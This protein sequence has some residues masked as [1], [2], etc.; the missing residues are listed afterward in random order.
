MKLTKEQIN[1]LLAEIR[2]VPGITFSDYTVNLSGDVEEVMINYDS[3]K[4][5]QT[6]NISF[7][8]SKNKNKVECSAIFLN[9]AE[10]NIL[11][12]FNYTIITN[13][14]YTTIVKFISDCENFIVKNYGDYSTKEGQL[15]IINN[16]LAG[17][18]FSM[19]NSLY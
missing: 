12:D 6:L 10:E 17:I 8:V 4:L 3:D 19:L 7:F 1:L 5:L 13:L 16:E 14:D 9:L 2:K 18:D 15:K 11:D